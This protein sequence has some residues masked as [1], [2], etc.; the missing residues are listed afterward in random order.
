MTCCCYQAR[1][2]RSALPLRTSKMLWLTF[3]SLSWLSMVPFK[4]VLYFRCKVLE[5]LNS[6]EPLGCISFVLSGK[7]RKSI[8]KRP[9]RSIVVMQ[10][11]H[12]YARGFTSMVIKSIR[13]IVKH[14]V[15]TW[16]GCKMADIRMFI[17]CVIDYP[18]HGAKVKN[19][20]SALIVI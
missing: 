1:A 3:E 8:R 19:D 4:V 6:F 18:T 16:P 17:K 15:S 9:K 12:Y 20:Y 2:P 11:S 10:Q 14:T 13:Y 7:I 5:I